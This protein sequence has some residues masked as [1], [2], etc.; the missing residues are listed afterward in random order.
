MRRLKIGWSILR[1]G[2][3]TFLL[4]TFLL[5]VL[6]TSGGF[7]SEVY[8]SRPITMIFGFSAGSMPDVLIRILSRAAEKELGQPIINENKPGG[9]GVIAANFIAKAKPDGYTLGT[10][11]TGTYTIQPQIAKVP[12]DP[13]K[14]FTPIMTYAKF[15]DGV[16]VRA[17]APWNTIEDV[18]EYA[19][20]NPNKFTYG[21]PGYG[22]SP[23]LVM[24][25][26]A[27]KNGMKWQQVPFKSGAEATNACLGH[28]VDACVAGSADLIPSVKAGKLKMVF[29]ISGDRFAET[30][31]VP[32]I[33]EKGHDVYMLSY[34]SIEG[35]K[36][37]PEPIRR[38]LDLA[39]KNA[40][41]DAT[42]QQMLKQYSIEEAYLTGEE[43]EKKWKAMY[44][45]MGKM[46]KALGLGE[47]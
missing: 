12:Y 11:K 31:N 10:T 38:K 39:F 24:E 37:L 16:C 36:G 6:F 13:F 22:M 30:P 35:P 27:M 5:T 1:Y 17:D 21:H 3:L 7:S 29:I 32:T 28:H 47:K 25:Y 42:F 44:P 23:H 9:S 20:K 46:V 41:K 26:F 2:G 34:M 4:A 33:L 15:N 14:D 40:I 8:P 43:Y 18:V 19:K 45:E